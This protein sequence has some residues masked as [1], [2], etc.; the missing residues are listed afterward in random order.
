[1]GITAT[2]FSS[3]I[4]LNPNVRPEEI[5]HRR[6]RQQP[7]QREHD[8]RPNQS[9]APD[10]RA[11]H[12]LPDGAR[13]HPGRHF[14]EVVPHVPQVVGEV[15]GRRV[16]VLGAL[17]QAALHDPPRRCRERGIQLLQRR[18]LAL[19]DGREG[20]DRGLAR[21]GPL[22]GGHLVHDRAQGE[23]VGLRDGRPSGRLLGRHVADG[24]EDDAEGRRRPDAGVVTIRSLLRRGLEVPIHAQLREPEVEDLGEPV[25]GHHDVLGLEIAVDDARAMGLGEALG[26]LRGQVD[27]PLRLDPAAADHVVQG[28]A[29]DQLHHDVR[30]AERLAD[31]VDGDDIGMVQ[32]RG[33]AG[34]LR[35]PR[36]PIGVG[37]VLR[38]QELD[39]DVALQI[40]IAR[41]KDLAHP[42]GTDAG[43]EFVVPETRA[44]GGRHG[45]DPPGS[46]AMWQAYAR[47]RA[48]S[49]A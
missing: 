20:L 27:G 28:E 34:L 18:R 35:K 16:A 39:G 31:L 19:E 43:E 2:R 7:E 4:R 32:R 42:S 5:V 13:S 6:H 30:L 12:P 49:R 21:E 33:G 17:G 38:R 45:R 40:E 46:G 1:M 37:G 11:G 36:Q 26:D 22:P 44:D 47:H 3:G 14:A 8:G 29:L 10:T 15:A 23:L 9:A 25:A 48:G 24:P 41:A